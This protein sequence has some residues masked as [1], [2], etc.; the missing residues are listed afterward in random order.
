MLRDG[1]RRFLADQPLSVMMKIRMKM[2]IRSRGKARLRLLYPP[3]LSKTL[4]M[5]CSTLEEVLKEVQLKQHLTHNPT[6]LT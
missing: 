5:I 4:L 6:L 3:Q 2:R 1:Q